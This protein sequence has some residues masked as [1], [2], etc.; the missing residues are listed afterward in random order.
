V[1][2]LR[3]QKKIHKRTSRAWRKRTRRARTTRADQRRRLNHLIDESLQLVTRCR[4]APAGPARR[5]LL[6][7]LAGVLDAALQIKP[8]SR[9][10]R[11]QRAG[12]RLALAEEGRDLPVHLDAQRAE[13]VRH[14]HIQSA[15]PAARGRGEA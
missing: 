13:R 15:P 6:E 2:S 4:R 14:G 8:S 11:E 9:L 10:L 1:R 3:P 5:A 12:C 7:R